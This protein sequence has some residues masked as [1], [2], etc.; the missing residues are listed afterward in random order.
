MQHC[1]I[2]QSI[3]FFEGIENEK[4]LFLATA[5]R[6]VLA[7]NSM[8][9][10]EGDPGNSCFY[11]E[12]GMVRIFSITNTG[13][14]PIF[15]LRRSGEIFGLSEVLGDGPRRANAQALIPTVLYKL[16]SKTFDS[17]LAHR[18]VL[19]QRVIAVLGSRVRY[20]GAQ[21]SNLM[22]CSVKNRVIKL[23]ISLIEDQLPDEEAWSH[24]VTVAQLSQDRIAAMIG[25]TQP[26][27]SEL[28]QEL[29]REGLIVVSRQKISVPQP[30]L[31]LHCAENLTT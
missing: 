12:T 26:T 31:L 6:C 13:K 21:I 24:P 1:S 17:L 30:L 15:F 4:K 25:S 29:Q 19:A 28:L 20:L 16:E 7:K 3:N 22:T 18:H 23:I 11:I 27:V 9:F 2:P 8:I 10:F 5:Q 14:E